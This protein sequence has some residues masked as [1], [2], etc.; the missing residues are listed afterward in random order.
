MRMTRKK[1]HPPRAPQ[2]HK[3]ARRQSQHSRKV[4]GTEIA[5]TRGTPQDEWVFG[6]TVRQIRVGFWED[7]ATQLH[8]VTVV[9]M[10]ALL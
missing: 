4:I 6:W 10:C 3:P 1:K 7:G 8:G 9:H 5:S 2:A